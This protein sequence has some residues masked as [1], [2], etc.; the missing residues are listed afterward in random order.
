MGLIEIEADNVSRVYVDNVEYV[1]K[2]GPTPEPDPDPAPDPD[3]TPTPS[4]GGL[5]FNVNDQR[6]Y[7]ST[8]IFAN[9]M[10]TPSFY[11]QDT[12]CRFSD[13]GYPQSGKSRVLLFVFG[14]RRCKPGR[15]VVSHSGQAKGPDSFTVSQGQERVELEFNGEI[16][17]DL[18]IRH[19][20]DVGLTFTP[21]FAKRARHAAWLRY[22]DPLWI[23]FH[24]DHY[25]PFEVED[26]R[27]VVGDVRWVH[28]MMTPEQIALI[29]NTFGANP[30]V[31]MFHL[32]TADGIRRWAE[33]LNAALDS[34]LHVRAENSNEIWNGGF[35]QS[36][37]ADDQSGG[38]QGWHADRTQL[39][40]EIFDDV[41]GNRAT[42]VLGSQLN[43]P[44]LL[45][46]AYQ[47]ARVQGLPNVRSV[48]VNGYIGGKWCRDN[49]V[50]LNSGNVPHAEIHRA[51]LEDFEKRVIPKLLEWKKAASDRGLALDMYESGLH[52]RP[53]NPWQYQ[54]AVD[55][56]H[57]YTL[58]EDAGKIAGRLHDFFKD[59]I[60]TDKSVQESY[61]DVKSGLKGKVFGNKEYE[62]DP[63][64]PRWAAV[65][66][67]MANQ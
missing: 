6:Y 64:P 66:T 50:R 7:Q 1:P 19:Q 22:L 57:E 45:N 10:A 59:E 23:N 51:M 58:T 24:A 56:L 41:F 46:G 27:T 65:M 2:S 37:Y 40:G 38:R 17:E 55:R 30:W 15:Y 26:V 21:T 52:C 31:P 11:T 35:A 44:G 48:A 4:V 9:L 20:D 5:G 67:R 29:S 3:P 33:R 16:G 13:T 49:Q 18:D 62:L 42:T 60:A 39:I 32:A 63:D 61:V 14:G 54:N 28:S 8:Q 43:S 12:S 25:E 47:K 36:K 34:K 53:L